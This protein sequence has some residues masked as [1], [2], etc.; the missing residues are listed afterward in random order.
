[1]AS[2]V[3]SRYTHLD[4]MVDVRGDE[5]TGEAYSARAGPERWGRWP[6]GRRAWQP[7]RDEIT[8]K[9]TQ[10]TSGSILGSVALH[11]SWTATTTISA[12]PS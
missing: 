12:P 1:M 11:L 3:C 5:S 7:D 9:L 6:V 4:A 10:P 2:G 8:S